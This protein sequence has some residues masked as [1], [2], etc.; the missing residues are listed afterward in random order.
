[1]NEQLLQYLWNYKIFKTLDFK[2]TEGN[3]I[4]IINF[5][6][7]NKDA[8]ADF[9]LAQIK[10][11][12]LIF[13]GHIEL[14]LR[15]SDWDFHQHSE[16]EQY[17]N[18]ILHAVYE[19]DR[20]VEFLKQRN[21]PTLELKNYIEPHVLEKYHKISLHHK[22]I[23]CESLFSAKYQ[24]IHFHERNVLN[25]LDEKSIL[26]EQQLSTTKN[27]YEAV[28][29][30]N[31]AYGFGLKVNAEIFQSIAESEGFS[32]IRKISNNFIQIEAFLFGKA[33]W[34][35]QV[36]DPQMEIWKREYDFLKQKFR[37]KEITYSPKFLRLRPPNFPTIRLSQLASLYHRHQNLFSKII[38]ATSYP[39]LKSVFKNISSSEYWKNHYQFG[40]IAEKSQDKKLSSSFIDLLIINVILPLKYTYHKNTE[41]YTTDMILQIYQ[42]ISAE[43]NRI[44]EGWE[45]LGCE[46]KTSLQSQSYLYQYKNFCIKKKC[47]SCTLGFR[48]I[49]N[50]NTQNDTQ[51]KA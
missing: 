22:F 20:E 9:Q 47:L 6:I 46:V 30:R 5:G 15:S 50:K 34:L 28:L 32:I 3:A 10:Y 41:G 40:K 39:E 29:F 33:G 48:I 31:M 8:G 18:I 26:I 14:H 4:E 2:D 23:P 38:N 49:G 24:P 37:L 11:K 25:K 1:M 51:S 43:K 21:I 12:G 27:D 45:A 19:H 17:H 16:N 7:W 42:E 36:L 35:S 13:S 44:V